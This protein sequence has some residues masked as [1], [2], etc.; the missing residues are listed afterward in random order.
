[1]SLRHQPSHYDY[2]G[3]R[4]DTA[5]AVEPVT[6]AEL[7]TYLRLGTSFTDA[8]ADD[9][10]EEARQYIEDIS[11]LALITQS[12]QLT[13]DRWP[14][15]GEPW[16][17]GTRQGH[18][19]MLNQ[20]AGSVQLPRYPLQSIT[21]A[22][23]YDEDSNSTAVTVA[24]VF[25]VDTQ[26]M[27]GRMT[28]Q[29]SAVWPTALRASNAIEV[30]YVAGYGDAGSDVPAPLKRAVK[31]LAGYLYA[32]RGDGCDVGDAYAKS[33]AAGIVGRYKVIKV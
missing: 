24:S 26:Q 14:N 16:W 33:G 8:M 25:D 23:T 20:G 6:A 21:S 10:I 9:L 31:Q 3:N 29:R 18:A 4:L 17:N 7:R 19:N 12:W 28:L 5:P 30:V 2:R 1:M 15:A 13:L 32:H 27:P 11:G 22:T